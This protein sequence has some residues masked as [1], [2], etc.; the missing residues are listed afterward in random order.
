MQ[1]SEVVEGKETG[2][3]NSNPPQEEEAHGSSKLTDLKYEFI[4]LQDPGFAYIKEH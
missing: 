2:K 4:S 3:S 1:V